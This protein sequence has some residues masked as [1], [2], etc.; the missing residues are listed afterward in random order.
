[1]G[2]IYILHL[3]DSAGMYGAEN[4]V[5]NLL[6]QSKKTN[7]MPILGCIRE[8]Q[9]QEVELGKRVKAEGVEVNYITI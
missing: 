9:N 5:L 2:K 3:I 4:V 7:F 8:T 1:M 6:C